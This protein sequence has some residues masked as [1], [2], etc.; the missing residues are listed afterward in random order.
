MSMPSDK[1]CF[2]SKS[3][4]K[5][6]PGRGAGEEVAYAEAY[7]SLRSRHGWRR[8]L[9]NFNECPFKHGGR[10]Y[11][12]VEHAFQAE[13]IR[14]ADPAAADTFAVESGSEL[15]LGDGLAAR[16]QRKLVRLTAAQLAL[17]DSSSAAAMERIQRAKFSACPA[18]AATL[19][20]TGRAQLWHIVPR[21]QPVRFVGL[22][23]V[24]A[25]LGV[26]RA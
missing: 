18:A 15:A 3:A 8:V 5:P 25:E 26:R 16:K 14:L 20:D 21:G 22:E 1:L 12:T 11:R 17:W 2:Y 4:D 9:S 10:T 24:R 6:V 19:L 7:A 13:K 23:R